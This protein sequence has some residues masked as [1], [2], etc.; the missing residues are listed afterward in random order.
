MFIKVLAY[1]HT[2][3]LAHRCWHVPFYFGQ[4]KNRNKRHGLNGCQT[5]LNAGSNIVYRN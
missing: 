4:V 1:N 2:I 5:H 3:K